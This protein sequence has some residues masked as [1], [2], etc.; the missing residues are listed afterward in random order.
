MALILP[1]FHFM[2]SWYQNLHSDWTKNIND[3]REMRTILTEHVVALL[4]IAFSVQPL[5]SSVCVPFH[6]PVSG[7]NNYKRLKQF[8]WI[9]AEC[10]W[11]SYCTIQLATCKMFHSNTHHYTNVMVCVMTIQLTSS[12]LSFCSW[13]A[14]SLSIWNSDACFDNKY[15]K[16][17]CLFWQLFNFYSST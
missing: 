16:I 2:S 9:S 1:T 6:V 11:T 4:W 14:F 15:F 13:C 12:L 7:T 3:R 5:T 8:H 10:L 17:W